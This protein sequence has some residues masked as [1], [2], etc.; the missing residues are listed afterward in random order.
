MDIIVKRSARRKKTIQARMVDGVIEVLA[1]ADM[2]DE[3]LEPHISSLRSRIERHLELQDSEK[4]DD[5][6]EARAKYLNE[7]YFGAKLDWNKIRYSTRQMKRHGSC[8]MPARTIRISHRMK[9]MPQ[10]V[11]DYVIF[12]ELAHIIEPNHGKR[13]K[14]LIQRYPLS[15][16]AIGFLLA[17]DMNARGG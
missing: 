17:M 11:E 16:R 13:F 14:A 10:W 2:T 9:D 1:P 4:G 7:K 8:T 3:D 6:L 15:E 5:H 12:H